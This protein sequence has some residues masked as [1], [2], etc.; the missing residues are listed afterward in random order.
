MCVFVCVCFC[1]YR[2]VLLLPVL[3]VDVEVTFLRHNVNVFTTSLER[4]YV[5][6]VRC[7]G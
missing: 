7:T 2:F 4:F 3:L 1:S 5:F 6:F